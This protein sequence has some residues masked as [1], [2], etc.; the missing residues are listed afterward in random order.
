M[1][2]T[3]TY[4]N[5]FLLLLYQLSH[6]IFSLH[7]FIMRG[8]RNIILDKPVTKDIHNFHVYLA[9]NVC[10]AYELRCVFALSRILR[11]TRFTALYKRVISCVASSQNEQASNGVRESISELSFRLQTRRFLFPQ[12]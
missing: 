12:S 8:V 1:S 5:S 10:S 9:V 4:K 7:C 11:R 2:K 3:S 6:Y